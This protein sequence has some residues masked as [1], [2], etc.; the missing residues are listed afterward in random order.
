MRPAIIAK[1]QQLV[2]D[3]SGGLYY[4]SIGKMD[5]HILASSIDI[6]NAVLT[7]DSERI[8]DLNKAHALPDDIFKI[9]FSS[10][11]IDGVGI[12][13][14][15]SK[16][17]LL[18]KRILITGPVIEVYH[19]EKGYN[20]E[21]RIKNDTATLYKKI[22]KKMK[23]ISIDTIEV[24]DGAFISH[25]F[26]KK[27]QTNKLNDVSII[28]NDVLIDSSTQYDTK[29]FLFAKQANLSTYPLHEP[30][31]PYKKIAMHLC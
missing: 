7:P 15:L 24:L 17:H 18:L 10:L 14:V 4:L 13:D 6:T 12:N 30:H 28:M 26:S 20:K 2:K 22:M 23:S 29:R 8:K 27:Y 9:S 25:L 3:G 5:L 21:L 11:H 19:K 16:D 31:L 1:L